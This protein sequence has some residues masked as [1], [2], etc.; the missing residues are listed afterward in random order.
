MLMIVGFEVLLAVVMN[1]AIC[2]D[3][4][5]SLSPT[6]TLA[7]CTA[8]SLNLKMEEIHSSETSVDF[9][10]TTWCY[11]PEASALHSNDPTGYI[12][13]LAI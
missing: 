5:R 6:F 13:C 12:K 8:Y 10:R 3:I 1:S 7:S 4:T 11:I 9:Q 2:W